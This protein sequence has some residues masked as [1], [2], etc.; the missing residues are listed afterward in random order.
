MTAVKNHGC[1]IQFAFKESKDNEIFMEEAIPSR[2][3]SNDEKL[4]IFA[5]GNNPE[6]ISLLNNEM[7]NN[8]KIRE[9]AERYIDKKAIRFDESSSIGPP[10]HMQHHTVP[11][12]A[13][14]Y[15]YDKLKEPSFAFKKFFSSFKRLSTVIV[16]LIIVVM[17]L[18][19]LMIYAIEF[20]LIKD[21]ENQKIPY[22]HEVYD[23]IG[24]PIQTLPKHVQNRGGKKEYLLEN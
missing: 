15:Q 21:K 9:Y 6:A 4:V 23:K 22:T 20:N 1:S 3:L 16:I 11:H 24:N 10:H 17:I 14:M 2:R 18:M 12:P 13:L 8:E 7:R 5:L 19:F